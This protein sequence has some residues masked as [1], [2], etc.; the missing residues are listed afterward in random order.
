MNIGKTKYLSLWTASI[1]KI[2]EKEKQLLILPEHEIN[3]KYSIKK[4]F[5]S[6]MII[7]ITF[8]FSENLPV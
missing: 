1:L 3:I 2:K 4:Y 8:R 7:G 6:Q 5:Y